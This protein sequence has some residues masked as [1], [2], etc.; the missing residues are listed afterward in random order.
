MQT[1][2]NFDKVA[3][4]LVV[5]GDSASSSPPQ[6]FCVF[7]VLYFRYIRSVCFKIATRVILKKP[8]QK[9]S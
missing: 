4:F 7:S 6:K 9:E 2:L 8:N 3:V 5:A 1:K